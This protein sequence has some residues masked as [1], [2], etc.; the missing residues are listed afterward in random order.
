MNPY[1]KTL[2]S[3]GHLLK[4]KIA[5]LIVLFVLA[6]IY[7]NIP[8]DQPVPFAELL[9]AVILVS[10]V[11]ILAPV[12]RLLVFGEAAQFAESGGL[13]KTLEGPAF[14]PALIHYW[15]ATLICYGTSLLCVSSLLS[16]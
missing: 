5:A 15:I 14:T 2:L 12:M 8:S 13:D 3:V 7:R 16:H 1:L 11:T 4:N 6:T 9:Y 10:A